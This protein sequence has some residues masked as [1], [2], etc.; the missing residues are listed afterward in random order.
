ME[1]PKTLQTAWDQ[2]VKKDGRLSA[3]E[4]DEIIKTAAPKDGMGELSPDEQDFL[5]KVKDGMLKSKDCNSEQGV[6]LTELA[7]LNEQPAVTAKDLEQWPGYTKEI[8]ADFNKTF[9]GAV[10]KNQIPFLNDEEAKKL[11]ALFGEDQTKGLQKIVSAMPDNKFGPETLFK[12]RI[13]VIEQL[14]RIS[15]PG[16]MEKLKQI[17]VSLGFE[18]SK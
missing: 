8:I 7:F 11:S 18:L 10:N 9:P 14:S 6:A 15:D 3:D 12:S 16:A 4:F 2:A 17:A 5:A 1:I 13:Y